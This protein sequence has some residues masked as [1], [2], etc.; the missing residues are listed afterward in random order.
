MNKERF[1]E[2]IKDRYDPQVMW[3]N[4]KSIMHKNLTYLFQIPIII[5]AAITPIFASLEYKELTIIS[6]ACVTAGIGILKY[7]KFE[8][9]WYNYRATFETL[10][11]EMVHYKMQTDVYNTVDDPE[12]L[13]V[14]RVESIISKEFAR[15]ATT[16]KENREQK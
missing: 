14:E 7:C 2:Y 1:D 16:V 12:N 10:N 13:F 11:K 4:K 8:D 15:W 6:S 5:L 3:Y 9:L